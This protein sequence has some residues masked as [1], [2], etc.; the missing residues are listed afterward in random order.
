MS[1]L[2]KTAITLVSLAVIIVILNYGV[3]YW[4]SQKLPSIIQSEKDF[5][6]NVSYEDLD[7]N[8]I[9]GSFTLHNIYV[10][11]KDSSNIDMQKG[12]FGQIQSIEV[13]NFNL[14]KLLRENH[15][16]VKKVIIK[17]P[18]ITLFYREKKYSKSEDIDPFKNTITTQSVLIEQGRFRML[19]SM[20]NFIAKAANINF[21]LN[22]ITVDSASVED[23]LP[24]RYRDYKLKCDSLFYQVGKEYHII[25]DNLNTTDTTVA[26]SNFKLMPE[27]SRIAF[28]RSLPKEKDQFRVSV[29]KIEI[30]K[31]DWGFVNDTLFVHSPEATLREVNAVIY[32]PKMPADDLSI[33]KLYSQSLRELN[34]D[35]KIDK[36]LLKDSFIQYEEQQDYERNAAKINFSEFYATVYNVYS[37]VNKKDVPVTKIDVNCLFMQSAPL[38]VQWSFDINDVSDSFTINGHLANLNT[39]LLNPM[40]GPLM[41]IKSSGKI[42]EV[43]FNFN[44]NKE[45]S[46]GT[47][48]IKYDNLQVEVLKSDGKDKNKFMSFVGNLI[49]KSDTKGDLKKVNPSVERDKT[50]SV[51]NF[52]WRFIQQGLKETILPGILT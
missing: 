19:D 11:P 49:A 31:A 20:Q 5:P 21:E 52:L 28:A 44:A 38:K 34:F 3:S 48:S 45:T 9:S 39:S 13:Q 51:F 42:T 17:E 43:A 16:K 23:N 10:S 1:A 6:Y 15:I 26:V 27:Q 2:K 18:D 14:W 36:L 40:S 46:T 22:N 8:L 37:P 50:K 32:R 30:P 25:A 41:N 29:S 35:L 4:I 7:L 12:A 33:K 24:L 47:F